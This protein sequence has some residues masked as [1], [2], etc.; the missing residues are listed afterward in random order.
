MQSAGDLVEK[1]KRYPFMKG[2]LPFKPALK[3]LG[4]EQAAV[5][6]EDAG[7]QRWVVCIARMFILRL[8]S[9]PRPDLRQE[10]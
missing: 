10:N 5:Y 1:F 8:L 4:T 9:N 7:R 3:E 6:A 2:L